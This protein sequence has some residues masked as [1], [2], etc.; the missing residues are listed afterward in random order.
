MSGLVNRGRV[1]VG[2]QACCL[3]A[4]SAPQRDLN[5]T[6]FALNFRSTARRGRPAQLRLAVLELAEPAWDPGDFGPALGEGADPAVPPGDR[7]G[8][9]AGVGDAGLAR[10]TPE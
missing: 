9:L 5:E 3:C 10:G 8:H 7:G 2:R 1:G 6:G 4:R